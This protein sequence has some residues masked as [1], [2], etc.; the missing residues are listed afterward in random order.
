MSLR[1]KSL[2]VFSLTLL[3]LFAI[4]LALVRIIIERQFTQIEADA[5]ARQAV[6]LK[7]EISQEFTP[8]VLTLKDWAASDDLYEFIS[9]RNPDF[10]A[11]N[12]SEQAL[13]NLRLDFLTI[14]RQDGTLLARQSDQA[15]LDWDKITPEQLDAAIRENSL[16]PQQ[17]FDRPE[18][19]LM[20]VGRQIALVA[21]MPI[22]HGDQ[23]GPVAGTLVAGRLMGERELAEMEQFAEFQVRVLP[24]GRGTAS[25]GSRAP[26][27]KIHSP[28][29][30]SSSIALQ[31]LRQKFVGTAEL[32]S[33]R[34]LHGQVQR[35]IHIFVI[36]LA[37]SA[38]ILLMVVWYLLDTNVIFPVRNMGEKLRRAAAAGELPSGLKPMGGGELADLAFRIE[39]LARA[40][41]H[42]EANYRGIVEDQTDFIFRYSPSGDITFVNGALCNYLVKSRQELMGR[43]VEDFVFEEDLTLVGKVVRDLSPASP[44]KSF[45]HRV[46]RRGGTMAWWRRTER[47]I[48]SPE[49]ELREY[50]SVARDITEARHA[51]KLIEASET[52]YRRLFETAT[53]GILIV[54][55]EK[56][57][58]ADANPTVCHLLQLSPA[59]MVGQTLD[60]LPH[61]QSRKTSS[62]LQTLFESKEPTRNVEIVLPAA[63]GEMRSV[64]VTASVYDEESKQVIQL[65]FRDVTIKRRISDELRQLSGKLMRLQDAERRR[66]A[67][68]LHDSTAQNLSAL[69][70]LLSKIE[71]LVEA[72]DDK[73]KTA[74]REI[75]SLTDLSLKEVR[76]IS[77][78]LHPPLLD[79][80]GL[81]FALRWYVDGFM[82][83]TEI[84][85]RLDVPEFLQ[86]LTPDIETT[87]FRIVQEALGNVHRHS[88][89]KRVWIRLEVNAEAI[90]L[91]IRDDGRGMPVDASGS[92][93]R[94]SRLAGVGIA[95]M[96][97]RLRQFGGKLY[98]DSGR[99]GT[100]IKAVL[101]WY[102]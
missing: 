48:F 69:Q 2:L 3:L 84:V 73:T 95:G 42:A 39:D 53:D 21:A 38:G 66:F 27:V 100:L 72:A 9:G 88:G 78:L 26:M 56:F 17:R 90:H 98:V 77:Y 20:L 30:I 70:M 40:V 18:V 55:R 74:F 22:V 12:L 71:P 29:L 99:E 43:K 50:Q 6:H 28:N 81:I 36:A 25:S 89:A 79:E 5:M 44:V 68:E 31:D 1:S 8:L 64:E 54:D 52:R 101:P 58:V 83:R 45:D 24:A 37:S 87:I 63:N 76:T 57:T 86:R 47:A 62:I 35:T 33:P 19:G 41:A 13:A 15:R 10:P 92:P 60:K 7:S 51:Q 94:S 49:G 75:R 34:T 16:V 67:R 14:W 80:V 91:E 32:T 46:K 65:N 85:V 11:K 59:L 97:E 61:L 4:V 93:L 82:A 23:Q 96:R 102:Q